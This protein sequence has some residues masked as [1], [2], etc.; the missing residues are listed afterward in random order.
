MSSG[1]AIPESSSPR[2]GNGAGAEKRKQLIG[3]KPTKQSN[4]RKEP[5]TGTREKGQEEGKPADTN[6]VEKESTSPSD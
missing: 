2:N 1:L 3:K 6:C 5:D 4:S